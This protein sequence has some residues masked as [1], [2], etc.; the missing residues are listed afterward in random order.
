MTSL[1]IHHRTK[2]RYREAV[3]F[4]P[5]RLMLRPR[6][7][8][9]LQLIGSELVVTPTPRVTWA[10]DVWGNAVATATFQSVHDTMVVDSVAQI[11]LGAPARVPHVRGDGGRGCSVI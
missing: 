2:Y 10:N 11:E 8:R 9:D 7:S 6:E 4:G 5:H 1:S 3:A